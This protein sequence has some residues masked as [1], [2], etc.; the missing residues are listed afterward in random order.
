MFGGLHGLQDAVGGFMGDEE[1]TTDCDPQAP[2][3]AMMETGGIKIIEK[4]NLLEAISANMGQEIE[5]ANRYAIENSDGEQIFFATEATSC[6]M[7]QIKQCF[8]DCSPWDVD[9]NYTKG[10]LNAPAYK[11]HRDWTFTCCCFNRPTAELTDELNGG[12]VVAT[13][14][15][16]WVCC[17]N[18]TFTIKNRDEEDLL[19]VNGGC[20]QMGLFCPLPCGPCAEVNFDVTDTEGNEVAHITKKIPGCCK[21]LMAPDVDNY[22]VD[23][24]KLSQLDTRLSMIMLAIFID[25]R[26]FNDSERDEGGHG[27][28]DGG[29][30]GGFFEE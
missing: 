19:Y 25:F 27:G 7:R 18:M 4:V 10:G 26:Y 3:Q 11:I 21:F 5:M 9:I 20:C 22:E 17:S 13:I 15:D 6:F 12:E 30:D 24:D 14:T 29:G 2:V 16:P 23:F 1:Q 28:G 8:G